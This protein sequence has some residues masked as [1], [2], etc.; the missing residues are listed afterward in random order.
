VTA[1]GDGRPGRHASIKALSPHRQVYLLFLITLVTVGLLVA[2][3]FRSLAPTHDSLARSDD[4]LIPAIARIERAKE[5]YLETA[6]AF[7][8]AAQTDPSARAAGI[9]R[10]TELHSEGAAAYRAYRTIA[11]GLPGEAELDAQ[12]QRDRQDATDAGSRFLT[13]VDPSAADLALINSRVDAIRVTLNGLRDLYEARIRESL[14]E[15]RQEVGNTQ[16]EIVVVSSLALAVLLVCFGAAARGARARERETVE[17]DRALHVEAERNE[18][19]AR[20]QRALEM[21][22][23]EVASYPLVERALATAAPHL[24]S[25]LLL[26]DS[27]RAHFRQVASSDEHGGPGCPVMSPSE[28]PAA[29]RGQT[30]V[31]DSSRSLDA[32][33]FL[34]DRP[35]GECS[36]ACI[37]VSVA[38]NT[39]GVVH[40]TAPDRHP[41]DDTTVDRF[42]LVAARAGERIGMLRAFAR[43]EAQAHTD[44]LTGLM[45]RRSLE[46]RLRDLTANAR[47][48]VVAY[49]DLD[50]FKQLNDVFGHD[51]GDQALRLFARVL[52]DAVRPDD[53]TARYGGEEF[54]IVLPDIAVPEARTVV[55]R[56]RERLATAREGSSIPP[57]TVSF[58][59]AASRPERT[60]SETL[61][62]ADAALLDAKATGRDRVVVAG[63]QVTSDAGRLPAVAEPAP[64]GLVEHDL[65]EPH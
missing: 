25:E 50:H 58:G 56:V 37:P 9:D 51:A 55:E 34:R 47:E 5:R 65:A 18:L 7:R 29:A 14:R 57:F 21:V 32:C 16:R 12:F 26:A 35:A 8:L 13:T 15:A 63:T 42:E 48:Y 11:Q 22:P 17:L 1:T 46:E 28:C 54:V 19:E 62:V 59:I 31:W 36:A 61:E 60:F 2:A 23:N 45:N 40:A 4:T 53:V 44:P 39:V 3:V 10:L 43:S 20:V 52:R 30:Q 27:S 49:G 6:E 24:P 33:P 41:P 64:G 38:G